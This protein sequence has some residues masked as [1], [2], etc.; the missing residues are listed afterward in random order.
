LPTINTA[1]RRTGVALAN[2]SA[3]RC[4]CSSESKP[5][6]TGVVLILGLAYSR[7]ERPRM[8]L[9]SR[10]A[11]V[12]KK[13]ICDDSHTSCRLGEI[14][15]DVSLN[16]PLTRAAGSQQAGRAP[17]PPSPSPR[18]APARFTWLQAFHVATS[19]DWVTAVGGRA[20]VFHPERDG[21]EL[22]SRRADLTK[23]HAVTRDG[24]APAPRTARRFTIARRA[25]PEACCWSPFILGPFLARPMTTANEA[26][27]NLTSAAALAKLIGLQS[28]SC[29]I[30][31]LNT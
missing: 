23:G 1:A 6:L 15:A 16:L 8:R 10:A 19:L 12:E 14:G 5:W 7:F 27:S 29:R 18:A 24:L 3:D 21:H 20:L 22:D 4:P 26:T 30:W 13:E 28:F 9:A 31:H 17:A 2:K 11:G 25:V